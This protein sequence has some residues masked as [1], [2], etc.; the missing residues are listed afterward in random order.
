MLGEEWDLGRSGGALGDPCFSS[1]ELGD[2]QEGTAGP[3]QGHL[4]PE[5]TQLQQHLGVQHPLGSARADVSQGTGLGGQSKHPQTLRGL[6]LT[7]CALLT[8]DLRQFINLC[9]ELSAHLQSPDSLVS[10]PARSAHASLILSEKRGFFS[11]SFHCLASET[12]ITTSNLLL[13]QSQRGFLFPKKHHI[14][15]QDRAQQHEGGTE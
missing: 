7:A 5:Q 1:W 9:S 10:S 14:T 8:R 4:G 13:K 3:W 12:G 2:L 6:K 11:F 15:C